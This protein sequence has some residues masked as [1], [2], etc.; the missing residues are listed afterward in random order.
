MTSHPPAADTPPDADTL[1]DWIEAI[2]ASQDRAAFAALFRHVAPRIKSYLM[3]GGTSDGAAE[4]LTQEALV[5]VWRKAAQFD[6]RKAR[7]S[8]WIFTIARN[9]RIDQL[10]RGGAAALATPPDL[11]DETA[12]GPREVADD[13][14]AVPDALHQAQAERDLRAALGRLPEEQREILRLSFFEDQPHAAIAQSLALP[15]GTVKSRIRL[16]VGH[17]RR[18]LGHL[19]P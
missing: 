18:Q 16:A 19:L 11:D 17:L 5:A 14:P 6:R 1:A 15:L 2:A 12:D 9:L 3:R 4:D 10:R 8:T 7:A 13:A